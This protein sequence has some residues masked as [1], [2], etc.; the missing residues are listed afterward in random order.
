MNFQQD[1]QTLLDHYVARYRKGDAKGCAAIYAV[2]A[3]LYSPYG[4]PVFGRDAIEKVHADWV[5]EGAENKKITVS[6]AGQSGDLGWCIAH[7]S[8]GTTGTGT[9]LN[10]LMRQPDGR[11]EI[12]QCSLN[13][14]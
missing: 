7:F 2:D 11:W 1:C 3:A 10:V 8:E 4:P 6:D 13:E 5:R 12:T 14:A 9:S